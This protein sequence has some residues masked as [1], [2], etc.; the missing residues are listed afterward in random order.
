M[1]RWTSHPVLRQKA[2]SS[3]SWESQLSGV[4]ASRGENWPT[5][6][7]P[8]ERGCQTAT[9]GVSRT[10]LPAKKASAEEEVTAIQL[11]LL[12]TLAVRSAWEQAIFYALE[13]LLSHLVIT[14]FQFYA[15]E[16]PPPK[17]ARFSGTAAAHK[18]IQHHIVRIGI[19]SD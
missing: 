9:I 2:S 15:P 5:Q 8:D 14:L 10:A 12:A 18:R 4:G 7:Y 13:P 1:V 3:S 17:E 6:R 19:G 16:P 11:I